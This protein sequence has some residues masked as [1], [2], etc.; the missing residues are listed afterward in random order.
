MQIELRC[1]VFFFVAV[2]K[3][4]GFIF[5]GSFFNRDI[6]FDFG[7]TEK[8]CFICFGFD[9]KLYRRE[10]IANYRCSWEEEK[11][12][13]V[14][15]GCCLDSMDFDAWFGF[16]DAVKLKLWSFKFEVVL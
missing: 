6:N 12:V 1:W 14:R 2:K 7:T 3:L 9:V 11:F 5:E 4:S 8:K 16:E 15:G 13:V 10:N